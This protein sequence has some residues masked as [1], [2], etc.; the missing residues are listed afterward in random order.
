M[1]LFSILA[2]LVIIPSFFLSSLADEDSNEPAESDK[3]TIEIIIQ[4][5]EEE[6]PNGVH[7]APDVAEVTS[8]MIALGGRLLKD[9]LVKAKS[10]DVKVTA[11]GIFLENDKS[12][13]E[14]MFSAGEDADNLPLT[15][16]NLHCRPQEG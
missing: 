15:E 1:K 3:N 14:V 12:S 9:P 8:E 7:N 16:D 2:I 6:D 5:G 10:F 4:I 11:L 13:C